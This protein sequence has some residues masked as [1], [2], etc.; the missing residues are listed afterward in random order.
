MKQHRYEFPDGRHLNWYEVGNGEPLVLLHGW[1]ISAAAY[2]ELAGM[3]SND[4]RLLIPDLPGHGASSPAR[5]NDF[6]A[7]ANDLACWLAAVTEGPVSLVGWSLG[8]MLSIQIAAD[9]LL[10]VRRMVL[11][12]VTP[13]FANGDDWTLGLPATQVHALARNLKRRFETA[14][15]DFFALTFADEDISRER[16]RII[17]NFAV[18]NQPL[19]DRDVVLDLLGLLAIQDQRD[20]LPAIDVPV[21]VLHGDLDQIAPVGA[22]RYIAGQVPDGTFVEF[23][24]VGHA[25]LLSQPG[26]VAQRIREF[27]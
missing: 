8:G 18:I 11:I 4:Y 25:P 1:S 15:G 24:G 3:L 9:D 12:G 21:L 2:S 14:L 6:K 22:G 13:R 23:A 20:V 17:R 26:E 19:P 10:A 27:C 7:L 5:S 16:L